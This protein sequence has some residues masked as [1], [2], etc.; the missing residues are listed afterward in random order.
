MTR[1]QVRVWHPWWSR[2][3]EAARLKPRKDQ[4]IPTSPPPDPAD[5]RARES[6]FTGG[7]QGLTAIVESLVHASDSAIRIP[8]TSFRV[9]LDPIVGMLLPGV[10]DAFGGVLSLSVVLLALHHR[11]P[12]WVVGKMVANLGIDAAIGVVPGVGDVFDFAWRANQRNWD[13]LRAHQHEALPAEMPVRYRFTLFLLLM[14]AAVAV[15]VP[16]VVSAYLLY[17]L[18]Q[19]GV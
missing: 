8:G 18:F 16:F 3:T 19:H 5:T 7:A 1:D 4:A 13:L 9:G 14:A 6:V 11:M 17:K 15:T 10:G 12:P 2:E